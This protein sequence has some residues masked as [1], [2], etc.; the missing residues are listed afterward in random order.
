MIRIDCG[1]GRL[2]RFP[3]LYRS[4]SQTFGSKSEV[5]MKIGYFLRSSGLYST[6]DMRHSSSMAESEKMR[7]SVCIEGVVVGLEGCT[8]VSEPSLRGAEQNR[9]RRHLRS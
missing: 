1:N 4:P 5:E 8:L 6:R 9:M 2:T 7:V 3:N